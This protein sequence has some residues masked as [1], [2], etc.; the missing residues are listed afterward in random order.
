MGEK[1]GKAFQLGVLIQ[2][3]LN[4]CHH[5]LKE[6]T[7]ATSAP[8]S[9]SPPLQLKTPFL[10]SHR[11]SLSLSLFPCNWNPL[12]SL[13]ALVSLSLSPI[14]LALFL[15]LRIRNFRSWPPDLMS[16]TWNLDIGKVVASTVAGV[17]REKER[18]RWSERV[19]EERCRWRWRKD[20][21][22]MEGGSVHVAAEASCH[23]GGASRFRASTPKLAVVVRE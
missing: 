20:S 15:S 17:K 14:S 23:G 3:V 21:G 10:L 7:F 1:L 16:A 22:R 5:T 11:L 12:P 19:G 6:F 13:S 8:S 4:N 18:E 9:P 2:S